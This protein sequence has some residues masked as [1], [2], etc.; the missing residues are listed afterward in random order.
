MRGSAA[1]SIPRVREGLLHVGSSSDAAPAEGNA[2]VELSRIAGSEPSHEEKAGL[3]EFD[4][5]KLCASPLP[6]S[7]LYGSSAAD[8]CGDVLRGTPAEPGFVPGKKWEVDTE[9]MVFSIS[10]LGQL[11]ERFWRGRDGGTEHA[12]NEFWP[13]RLRIRRHYWRT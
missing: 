1:G 2:E 11:D 12:A 13:E 8:R 10:R 5:A 7:I 3:L 6:T 9:T 4:V